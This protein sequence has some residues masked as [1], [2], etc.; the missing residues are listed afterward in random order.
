MLE[1]L[2]ASDFRPHVGQPFPIIGEEGEVAAV[3]TEVREIPA[4][5]PRS[6]PF[7][8]ILRGPI[9]PLLPQRTYAVVHPNLGRLELFL[10]PVK[11]VADGIEYEAIFN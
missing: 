11:R 1:R 6:E 5:G 4:G 7:A 10:V 2:T 3:L 8:I 9:A